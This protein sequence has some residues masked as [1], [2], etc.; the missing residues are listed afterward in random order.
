MGTMRPSA[1]GSSRTTS[2]TAPPPDREILASMVMMARED[3]RK[4]ISLELHD[5]AIQ[6]MLAVGLRLD[7]FLMR[8][9]ELERPKELCRLLED[10][11]ESIISLR[12]MIFQLRPPDLGPDG[13]EAALITCVRYL[14][15]EVR[16][17]E[18]HVEAALSHEPSPE[19]AVLL[20]RLAQEAMSNVFRHARA[21]TVLV[22]L[23]E[24]DGGYHLRIDDDGVGF[25]LDL[26]GSSMPGHLGLTAMQERA[27]MAGGRVRVESEPGAGT[28]V[29]AWIPVSPNSASK[30]S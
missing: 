20:Y 25:V 6:K 17:P 24:G 29:E 13:L 12:R 3:E 14:A 28:R 10:V 9:P 18:V 16:S 1:R 23:T 11:D 22:V 2:K 21:S 5:D 27:E 26:D 8:H 4:R 30:V 7:L 19:L 15:R